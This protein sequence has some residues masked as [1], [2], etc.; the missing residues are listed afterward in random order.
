MTVFLAMIFSFLL[1]RYRRL[2]KPRREHRHCGC[3]VLR[4]SYGLHGAHGHSLDAPSLGSGRGELSYA[5]HRTNR[6][7]KGKLGASGVFRVRIKSY[8]KKFI[9]IVCWS[10]SY[11]NYIA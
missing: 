2:A 6:A 1:Q 9:I 11:H 5:E 10:P 8:H 7:T 3:G 4:R